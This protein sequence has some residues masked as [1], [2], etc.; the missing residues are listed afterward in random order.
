MACTAKRRD[1]ITDAAEAVECDGRVEA[2][3]T[4]S[5]TDDPTDRWS[6]ELTLTRAAG[7]C[8][9]DLGRE[10]VN[11]GLTIREVAPK[12]LYWRVVATC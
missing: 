5:P 7:G 9:P 1:R 6:L 4:V 10:L 11:R 12:G 2:A 8:P 3:K